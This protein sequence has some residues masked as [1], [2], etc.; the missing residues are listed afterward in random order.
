M[1]KIVRYFLSLPKTLYA[2]L[3][4]FDIPTAIKLP[5]WIS[6]KTKIGSLHKGCISLEGEIKKVTFGM[7][8]GSFFCNDV[9]Y[10]N[11]SENGKLIVKGRADF[12]PGST[13]NITGRVILG[14]NFSANFG[15]ALSCEN[16]VEAGDNVLLGWDVSIIDGDGH[17]IIK[18][19]LKINSP[20]KIVIGNHVW[21][22]AKSSILK[23]A[24][25]GDD[26]V[27]GYGT[28]V[29]KNFESKNHCI[30]GGNP[31]RVVKENCSWEK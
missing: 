13:V 16:S 11:F 25:I 1:K 20:R 17:N 28:I 26:C 24:R 31:A 14:N 7:Y 29:S 30:I 12:G 15:F 23:G 27:V 4:M 5:V 2:N 18:D 10:L 19:G 9:G 22:C 8:D 6:Y 3:K 21:L